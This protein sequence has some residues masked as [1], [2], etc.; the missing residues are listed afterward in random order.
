MLHDEERAFDVG[1]EQ[2][3]ERGL[4]R[5][6]DRGASTNAGIGDED[7]EA[8]W[9]A[10]VQRFE[11]CLD[12]R[13]V[14]QIRLHRERAAA[15]LVDQRVRRLGVGAIMHRHDGPLS[16]QSARHRRADA[17]RGAGDQCR[18]PLEAVF[19]HHIPLLHALQPSDRNQA[20]TLPSAS[21]RRS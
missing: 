14:A 2:K 15:D 6:R 21:H 1:I 20:A 8:G 13:D 5:I 7:V 10:P 16:R 17:T 11:H 4:V 19:D 12:L 9:K 18:F 3:I